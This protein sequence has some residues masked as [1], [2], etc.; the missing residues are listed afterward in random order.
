MFA[1]LILSAVQSRRHLFGHFC[2]PTYS[3]CYTLTD[4]TAPCR[5]VETPRK[6]CMKDLDNT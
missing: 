5:E 2:T 6:F 4:I 3:Y 1:V